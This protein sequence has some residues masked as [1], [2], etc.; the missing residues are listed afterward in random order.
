[1]TAERGRHAVAQMQLASIERNLADLRKSQAE[2]IRTSSEA[3]AAA[4]YE[5]ADHRSQLAS[6]TEDLDRSAERY[7][8][9]HG[10]LE[11]ELRELLARRRQLEALIMEGV[12]EHNPT[13]T[14]SPKKKAIRNPV[15]L[16][17]GQPEPPPID[18][19]LQALRDAEAEGR[20]VLEAHLLREKRA[21]ATRLWC[22][23]Q[24]SDIARVL[25]S[26][27][28]PGKKK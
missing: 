7:H 4:G 1:M 15:Q 9:E 27:K 28:K 21:H 16:M 13:G 11:G 26:A 19:E 5:E 12:S 10:R 23:E 22:E 17:P 14:P 24:L 8:E 3:H 2:L 20:E 18:A 25:A 6:F